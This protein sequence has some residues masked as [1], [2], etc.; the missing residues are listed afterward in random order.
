VRVLDIQERPAA[1]L[2]TIRRIVD[3]LRDLVGERRSPLRAQAAIET[4]RLAAVFDDCVRRAE[5]AVIADAGYLEALGV[6][7]GPGMTA[8]ELWGRLSDGPPPAPSLASR[9]HQALDRG[10]SLGAV[11]GALCDCLRDER[12]FDPEAL[13]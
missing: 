10:R 4:E 11:Y 9:I 8:G 13:P 6:N 2:A 3:A 7:G 12:A 1:D 5:G